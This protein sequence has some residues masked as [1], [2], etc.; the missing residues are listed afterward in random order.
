MVLVVR[1][2]QPEQRV[3]GPPMELVCNVCTVLE[4]RQAVAELL[5]RPVEHLALA[6]QQP[7]QYK[8]LPISQAAQVR[9]YVLVLILPLN[10]LTRKNKWRIQKYSRK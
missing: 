9:F 8:W 10:C 4:L 7:Q 2:R 5:V 6:K 3:Y 1:E